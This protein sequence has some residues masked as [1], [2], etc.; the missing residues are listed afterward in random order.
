MKSDLELPINQVRFHY[1]SLNKRSYIQSSDYKVKLNEA[2]SGMQSL[3]PMFVVLDYLFKV[4]TKAVPVQQS[5]KSLKEK[6]MI[7]KR[8]AEILKDDSLDPE[9]RRLLLEQTADSSN[10]YLLS[11]VE[12]PEENL[13]PTS[14]REILNSL[15]AYTSVGNNKL[16]LTTHSPYILNYLALAIKA[17]NVSKKVDDEELR[18]RLYAIVPAGAQINGEDV[19]VYQID[20]R[21]VITALPSYDGMPSDDNY[22]NNMLAECNDLFNDLLDVEERCE[23]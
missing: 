2:S 7:Q 3:S 23:E 12:E 8:I 4:V 14:Q 15:L 18:K 9:A 16:L 22:L 19:S 20:G 1:D 13:F 21:G 17:W 10:K 5:D 11:I 6:E